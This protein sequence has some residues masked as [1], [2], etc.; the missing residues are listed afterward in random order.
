MMVTI[1]GTV[2][3]LKKVLSYLAPFVP[4]WPHFCP[5]LL[6]LALI[7]PACHRLATFGP[8]WPRLAPFGYIWP[9][10][11]LLG[12]VWPCLTPCGPIWPHLVPIGLVLPNP[13]LFGSVWT[14]WLQF[15]G[16]SSLSWRAM[17]QRD[18]H[19][20]NDIGVHEKDLDYPVLPNDGSYCKHTES[21]AKNML[22]I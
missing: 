12:P 15:A 10:L 14:N 9:C 8:A 1:P 19:Y 16:T 4:I 3:I 21:W 13:A 5:N 22:Y 6:S 7:C 11:A 20:L 18:S 17:T 2:T